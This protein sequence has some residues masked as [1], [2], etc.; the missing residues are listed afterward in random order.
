MKITYL[1]LKNFAAIDLT[2]HIKE[3]EIDFT[4]M[5]NPILLFIGPIGSCKTYILSQLQPFAYMGNVDLRHGEDMIISDKD[6]EKEIHFQKSNGDVYEIR[7][8]Y[9]RRKSNRQIKSYIEKNGVE[10]N[11]S[12]L[13][14]NFNEIIE[15]EF[16][17]DIGFLKILRLG[18]NVNNLVRLSHTNRK[19]FAVK[20]LSEIDDYIKDYKNATISSRECNSELSIIVDKLKKFGDESAETRYKDDLWNIEKELEKLKQDLE[21]ANQDLYTAKGK[22]ES[23]VN[24]NIEIIR[25]KVINLNQSRNDVISQLMQISKQMEKL[26]NVFIIVN[27]PKEY[28]NNLISKKNEKEKELAHL[29]GK[30]EVLSESLEN[31]KNLLKD[32]DNQI[33]SLSVIDEEENIKNELSK[34]EE[35]VSHFN[36]YYEDF[37]PKCTKAELLEDIALMQ[38]IRDLILTVRELS[39]PSRDMFYSAYKE[40][41]NPVEF[42]TD[43]MVKLKTE[44]NLCKVNKLHSD[45]VL[46]P[47]IGCDQFYICP[48][49]KAYGKEKFRSI[50]DIKKD[51]DIVN[52]ALKV[53]DSVKSLYTIISSR[54]NIFPYTVIFD[55]VITDIVYGTMRF[56]D[57]DR[58][59]ATITFLERYEEWVK[60]KKHIEQFKSQ[61][62]VIKQRK[63]TMD[64]NIIERRNSLF[65]TI[66]KQQEDYDNLHKK[67]KKLK[68]SITNTEQIIEDAKTFYSLLDSKEKY[69]SSLQEIDNELIALDSKMELIKKFDEYNKHMVQMIN[70]IKSRIKELESQHFLVRVKLMEF[71]QLKEEKEKLT[72][73]FNEVELIRNAVSGSKGIPLLYLNAHFSRART[74]A[75]RIISEVCGNYLQLERI[76][77]DDKEFRIPYS[78]NGVVISDVL[79]ASQGETSIISM[80]LS[81][82]LIE[83]FVGSEGYNILLLDEIDGPLDIDIKS[84][85]LRMLEKRMQVMNCEQLFMITHSPLFENYPVDVF[86][87]IEQDN[88]LDSY[89]NI[90]LIN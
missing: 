22:I 87:T 33:L 62:N 2:L 60:A 52:E 21:K 25:N 78:K 88:Q 24:S 47:P 17:I 53:C 57:F 37:N 20:L 12:G 14:T 50:Y 1:R 18:S 38:R 15:L 35:F 31:N 77:I 79:S 27:D 44:L 19:E 32:L 65:I 29:T 69:K 51:I 70:Q 82:A 84:H 90:N 72:E 36:Q 61:L 67:K 5:V 80:A 34:A 43:K 4:K 54:R 68:D 23:Q 40:N 86:V 3:L 81:F 39:Q 42:C 85:L 49:V 26:K 16:G 73:K 76:I 75:N 7:H 83:E 64:K 59:N 41:K 6:G 48:Y 63:E 55:D 30:L 58:S 74:I 11:P 66:A 45:A 46:I 8:H 13:V 89:K 10:L 9:L 56:F 28:I 71:K